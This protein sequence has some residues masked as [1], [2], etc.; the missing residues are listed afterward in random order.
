VDSVTY[1]C[2]DGSEVQDSGP[3]EQRTRIITLG[4]YSVSTVSCQCVPV[5]D[6]LTHTQV[7]CCSVVKQ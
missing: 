5:P 1:G 7:L 4:Y 3:S 6:M 2:T